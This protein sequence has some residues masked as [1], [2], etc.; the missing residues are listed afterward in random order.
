MNQAFVCDLIILFQ[1]V[2]TCSL[3]GVKHLINVSTRICCRIDLAVMFQALPVY[4]CA[5]LSYCQCKCTD[6]QSCFSCQSVIVRSYLLASVSKPSFTPAAVVSA[7]LCDPVSLKC[8]RTDLQSCF[9]CQCVIVQCYL[10]VSASALIF[11]PVS[12][13]SACMNCEIVCT[14]GAR[15]NVVS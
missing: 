3:L 12:V 1:R 6:L 8:K 11:S 9:G 5:I 7:S 2:S 13:V 15:R 14:E 10:S 4:H